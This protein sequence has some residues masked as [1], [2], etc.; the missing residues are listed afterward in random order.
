MRKCTCNMYRK[1]KKSDISYHFS[2]CDLSKQA[3]KYDNAPWYK[4]IFLTNP[5]KYIK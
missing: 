1:N 2:W 3:I 5:R 4:R